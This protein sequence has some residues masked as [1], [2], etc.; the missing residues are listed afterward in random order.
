MLT[1]IHEGDSTM[2][3]VVYIGVNDA[4]GIQGQLFKGKK[5]WLSQKVPQ[6]KRFTEEVKVSRRLVARNFD[7]R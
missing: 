5:F 1:S 3:E 4:A 6:R 2:A 7:V